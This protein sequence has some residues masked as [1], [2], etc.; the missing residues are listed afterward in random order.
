MAQPFIS[1][2][3]DYDGKPITNV[4]QEELIDRGDLLKTIGQRSARAKFARAMC[5]GSESTTPLSVRW[6]CR[7]SAAEAGG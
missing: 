7:G 2:G 5:S 1:H 3:I 4:T 6:C